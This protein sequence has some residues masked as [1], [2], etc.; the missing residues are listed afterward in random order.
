M[1]RVLPRVWDYFV[2]FICNL[3]SRPLRIE[4][5]NA[6]YHVTSRGNRQ[7]AIFADDQDRRQLLS[8][9]S[10]AFKRF[11]ACALA[12]CLMEN[13]YHI[14]IQ[15]RQANL[16]ALMRQIN[17]TYTQA[18]NRRHEN[19]GHVFQG[20][21]K[22]IL[23]NREDH[24]L[25]VCR[26]VELNPIRACLSEKI[27]AWAWSSYAQLTGRL[28]VDDWLDAPAIWHELLG[29]TATNDVD[30]RQAQQA[31][32]ALVSA[33]LGVELWPKLLRQQVYL[34][35]AAFI[36][37]MQALANKPM[38][39]TSEIPRAQR[40]QPL[41]LAEWLEHSGDRNAAIFNAHTQSLISLSAIARELGLSTSRVSRIVKAIENRP[42]MPAKISESLDP[43]TFQ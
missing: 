24:L 34:G 32:A 39:G 19:G 31:Y 28:A 14:V 9:W 18:F 16:S 21:F 13:H 12:W 26:Y 7:E 33:G 22:A 1:P 5:A 42:D 29:Y 10:Q 15:T 17:G 30:K 40:A 37:R 25:E 27:E 36:S 6:V 41:T 4:F 11:D 20:R 2:L 38:P 23:V 43:P 8:V 35:D 3:M